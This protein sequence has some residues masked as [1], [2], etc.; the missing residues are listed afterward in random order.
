[1]EKTMRLF[2]Q[3]VMPHFRPPGNEPFYAR[4]LPVPGTKSMLA[5]HEARS[6]LAQN[7]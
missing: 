3:E 5:A 7:A 6:A 1:M 4:G 2:S